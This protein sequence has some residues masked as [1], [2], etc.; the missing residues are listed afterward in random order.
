MAELRSPRR[1]A[2]SPGPLTLVID[3]SVGSLRLHNSGS[4]AKLVGVT[5]LP[6]AASLLRAA[7]TDGTPVRA[8]VPRSAHDIDDDTAAALSRFLPIDTAA[9]LPPPEKLPQ[10]RQPGEPFVCADVQYRAA[11]AVLGYQPLP[12]PAMLRRGVD[13]G[14]WFLAALVGARE[15]FEHLEVIPYDLERRRDGTWRLLGAL[16][17]R[18]AQDAEALGVAVQRIEVDVGVDDACLIAVGLGGA[19]PRWSQQRV[20]WRDDARAVVAVGAGRWRH[21]PRDHGPHGHTIALVPAPSILQ[22]P[23]PTPEPVAVIATESWLR[24]NTSLTLEAVEPAGLLDAAAVLP[25]C[26]ATTS[27]IQSDLDRLTGVTPLDAAGTIA[28]RHTG[29]PDNARVVDALIGELQ[30]VGY[31]PWREPFLWSGTNRHNVVADLPGTGTLRLRPDVI[32]R[33]RKIL[34]RWPFPDPPDPWLKQLN[35]LTA[36]E[37]DTAGLLVELDL[38]DLPPW[39]L[40]PEVELRLGLPAW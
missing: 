14:G 1:T 3:H 7:G 23:P 22:P 38:E 9:P 11:A 33:L 30:A 29:H 8:L 37:A 25:A 28:S 17:P 26:P 24:R 18:G 34:I 21:R 27:S 2:R 13:P 12:H 10:P 15:L 20:V 6:D 19:T 5:L 16:Q 40:R 39:R 4:T 36:P 35:K 31:C 32:E